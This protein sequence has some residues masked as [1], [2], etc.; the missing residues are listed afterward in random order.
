MDVPSKQLRYQGYLIVRESVSADTKQ[1]DSAFSV[2][3]VL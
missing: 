1:F 2:W 3:L